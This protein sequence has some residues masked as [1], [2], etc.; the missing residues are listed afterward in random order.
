MTIDV[1]SMAVNRSQVPII[2]KKIETTFQKTDTLQ[3]QSLTFNKPFSYKATIVVPKDSPFTQP[4]WLKIPN[5]GKMYSYTDQ[6][7]IY[8][9]ESP[10]ALT[11]RFDLEIKGIMLSYEIPV[12]HRWN[13]A[14]K[15]EQFRPFIIQ[16]RLSV[17]INKSTYIFAGSKSHE[18]EVNIKSTGKG[19]TGHIQL[20]LPAGWKTT[21]EHH[22]YKLDESGDQVIK[23]FRIEPTSGAQSGVA[24]AVAVSST[25][26]KY[27]DE[28]IEIQYDHIPP[29]TVLQPAKAHLVNLDITVLP[30]R[31]GYIMGSGDEIPE[32][33]SQLGYT[34]DLLSDED[35]ERKILLDYET[36][37]C[38]IRAFNTRNE[39]VRLQ[40]RLITYVENGGTW[41]VQ[42]NTRFGNQANQIGPYPFSASGRDRISDE[43][44]PIQMLVPDHQ[45]FNY[46][47]K[48][49]NGDFENWVQ[50]RGLYFADS[51][52][53][54]LYPLLAGN[55]K[56][57]NS[58]LGG[59][60][61]AQYGKGVFIFTAYSWFRQLPAGVPGAY[62]L[63]VNMI[64]AKGN[65]E[66]EP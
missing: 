53:G 30:G 35:L 11:T 9:T 12:L 47:N 28:I 58:K 20:E 25:G 22:S 42:H 34:V 45:I 15:G 38:G 65:N 26:R 54:K 37:I 23:K 66:S 50:E 14:I 62:R 44:A 24:S 48:I 33:L 52:E 18:I 59:L 41:I 31:I 40:K 43:N 36:I 57:E 60:L 61:F 63:F 3:S 64:S 51:W 55:D 8:K 21:P 49:T 46:P 56:G 29:Q 4:F 16:P 5:N 27:R 7:Q 6:S 17:S 10:P 32:A 19:L 13:D 1:R 2:V 39:L